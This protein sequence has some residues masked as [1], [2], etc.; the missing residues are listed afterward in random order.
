METGELDGFYLQLIADFQ[1][2]FSLDGE[3]CRSSIGG[4]FSGL[5]GMRAHFSLELYIHA[6]GCREAQCN[7]LRGQDSRGTYPGAMSHEISTVSNNRL[8]PPVSARSCCQ[9]NIWNKGCS[10]AFLKNLKFGLSSNFFSCLAGTI[11]WVVGLLLRTCGAVQA[12]S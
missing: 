11:T 9:S 12:K 4:R 6:N 2:E 8:S 1:A 10:P 3:Q 5:H 7:K